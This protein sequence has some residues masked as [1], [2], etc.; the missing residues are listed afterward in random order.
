LGEIF[1]KR[2]FIIG[3]ILTLLIVNVAILPVPAQEKASVKCVED[4]IRKLSS[5]DSKVRS[6]ACWDL[7][8]SGDVRAIDPL[9]LTLKDNDGT[10]RDWATLALVKIGKSS[11]QPL[12]QAIQ[13]YN[14]YNANDIMESINASRI[15]NGAAS[16][17]GLIG[18]ASAVEPL[19]KLLESN[20]SSTRYWS[21]ISLGQIKDARGTDPLIRALGD[22][23]SSVS[24][25][26][27]WAIQS[28]EGQASVDLFIENLK[29]E[30]ESIRRGAAMALGTADDKKAVEPLIQSLQ[31]SDSLVR[32]ESATSL[33]KINN[34]SAVEPL[35]QALKDD[36]WQVQVSVRMA[37]VK[38]GEDGTTS[39]IKALDDD[40]NSI[41]W[42][43]ALALGGIR[44]PRAIEPLIAAFQKSDHD[45]RQT[46]GSALVS[47]NKT[48]A[49]EPF[50]QILQ[51]ENASDEM[52]SDSAMALGKMG[53]ERA[54]GALLQAM[55]DKESNELRLS[56]AKALKIIKK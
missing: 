15:Q 26:A 44:D 38:I 49:V 22:S 53:D 18:D 56:A 54:I 8:K 31:D 7:G 4:I 1:L 27:G 20:N 35:I 24:E 25:G 12:V 47:I 29:N 19:A 14:N 21:A 41:K 9:I 55:S 40:N 28:I 42:G 48:C 30:N 46:I 43:A 51:D 36:D 23:N 52:R 6:T 32:A 34:A 2:I 11:I 33:G 17:L 5:Q 10:V 16:A 3:F 39:L 37:L 50:L 13:D 45:V